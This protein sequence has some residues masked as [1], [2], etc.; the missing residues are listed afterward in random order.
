MSKPDCYNCKNFR[1]KDDPWLDKV[2]LFHYRKITY[3]IKRPSWIYFHKN[4]FCEF[5]EPGRK[6]EGT[7]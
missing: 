1:E 3:C 7:C 5:Y 6:K 2:G 4:R